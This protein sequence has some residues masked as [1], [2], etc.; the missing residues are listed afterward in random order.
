MKLREVLVSS[1][2]LI[3]VSIGNID[4]VDGPQPN[5]PKYPTFR[6]ITSSATGKEDQVTY[7][8]I[9]ETDDMAAYMMD[10]LVD[11]G[12]T[13]HEDE[14]GIPIIDIT[15]QDTLI[16]QVHVN[17][18]PEYSVIYNSP[19]IND[20]GTSFYYDHDHSDHILNDIILVTTKD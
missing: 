10:G 16:S 15:Y 12:Y 13:M 19:I 8:P 17:V 6:S 11:Y 1:M 3:A 14:N 9:Y 4:A 18:L 2:L 20:D 5:E 7:V